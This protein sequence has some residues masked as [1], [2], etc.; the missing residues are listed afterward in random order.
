MRA[1]RAALH[2]AMRRD[3]GRDAAENNAPEDRSIELEAP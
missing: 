3:A 2:N 1:R